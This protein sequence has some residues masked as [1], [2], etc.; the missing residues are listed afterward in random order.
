MSSPS[1]FSLVRV[2]LPASQKAYLLVF[3]RN[4][5]PFVEPDPPSDEISAFW[6]I[7]SEQKAHMEHQIFGELAWR[8]CLERVGRR[9]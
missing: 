6:A 8:S 1:S 5:G 4:F 2:A 3:L 7:K 9:I